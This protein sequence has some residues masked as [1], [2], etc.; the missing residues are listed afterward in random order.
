MTTPPRAAAAPRLVVIVGPTGAGKTALA[1]D[2]ALAA[3]AE[4]VSCD[5]QQVYTGM[6]LGTG[7]ATAAERARVRHHLLDVLRPDEEMTAARFIALADAAIA[8]AAA[9]GRPVVVAGG[10]GLYVRALLFGLFEGPGADPALRAALDARAAAAGVPALHA[11]LAAVD[12]DLAARVDPHDRK[13]IVRALEVFTLTG[14]PMSEHQRRHDHRAVAP[15]YPHRVVGL[16]P[17]RARLYPQIDARVDAML[18]AGLVDEVAALRAAG[19]AP[20]LRSQQ[21]IGYAELHEHLAGRLDLSAAIDLVK[22]NSRR[23]ARRQLAW[24]RPDRSVAWAEHAAAVDLG[25]LAAYLC[26]P[27]T[28]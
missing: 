22:R 9:R 10:T 14:T 2:L 19:Y 8:D 20:P 23:Y 25:A 11:E 26:D 1:V 24:Y 27:A 4:I 21:A 3:G 13:R 15:R 5:S 17:P 12:P 7:K 16:A 6:D 18:A 28:P